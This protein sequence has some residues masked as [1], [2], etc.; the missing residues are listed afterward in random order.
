MIYCI[1]RIS[2]F[3]R[4]I[5]FFL[6]HS[7]AVAKFR[8]TKNDE[9]ISQRR[10]RLSIGCRLNVTAEGGFYISQCQFFDIAKNLEKVILF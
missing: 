10:L 1:K 2:F 9:Q 3:Y 5:R 4:Q 8:L 6:I 7:T